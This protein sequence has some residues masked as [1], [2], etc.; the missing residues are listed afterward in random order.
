MIQA[1]KITA[2]IRIARSELKAGTLRL[3]GKW[4]GR[5]CDTIHT[6]TAC[7]AKGDLLRIH[8]NAG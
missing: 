2:W 3:W 5:P 8:F 7:D 4:F 6:M 1:R